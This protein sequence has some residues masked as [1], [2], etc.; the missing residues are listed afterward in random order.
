[1]LTHGLANQDWFCLAHLAELRSLQLSSLSSDVA[2]FKRILSLVGSPRVLPKLEELQL[3]MPR[4]SH[5]VCWTKG[6]HQTEQ[7]WKRLDFQ[8]ELP[9]SELFRTDAWPYQPTQTDAEKFPTAGAVALKP[10]VCTPSAGAPPAV[11]PATVL[12]PPPPSPPSIPTATFPPEAAA[13]DSLAA[14]ISA[15]IAAPTTASNLFRD[16]LHSIFDF[17]TLVELNAASHTSRYWLTAV[18]SLRPR[19][20]TYAPDRHGPSISALLAVIRS[21]A[22]GHETRHRPCSHGTSRASTSRPSARAT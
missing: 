3:A 4:G 18:A 5:Q 1:V 12:P 16:G 22:A 15:G 6:D 13:A 10:N 19:S 2:T 9:P 11:E 7:L 20:L 21:F 17:L 8:S 14:N